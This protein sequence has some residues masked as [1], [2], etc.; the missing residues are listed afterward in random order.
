MGEEKGKGDERIVDGDFQGV[1]GAEDGLRMH[2]GAYAVDD[3]CGTERVCDGVDAEGG[4]CTCCCG[5]P[6]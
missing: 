5:S 3:D 6:I 4:C 1:G 2:A